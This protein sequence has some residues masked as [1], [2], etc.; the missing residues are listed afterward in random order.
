[1][2]VR[3]YCLLCAECG[4]GHTGLLLNEQRNRCGEGLEDEL[5][6]CSELELLRKNRGVC[7]YV[8]MWG[9]TEL[10]RGSP[11]QEK[12][13]TRLS[14]LSQGR[15]DSSSYW[16]GPLPLPQFPT[17]LLLYSERNCERD[18]AATQKPGAVNL[19]ATSPSSHLGQRRLPNLMKI[20]AL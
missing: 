11:I 18:V 9:R 7:V 3:G 2:G 1:M 16:A 14:H 12:Q 6:C 5:G 20:G 13:A 19:T 17:V 10:V 15:E 4:T 8:C